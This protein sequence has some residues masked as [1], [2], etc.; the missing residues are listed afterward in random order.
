MGP[1]LE[2][3]FVFCSLFSPFGPSSGTHFSRSLFFTFWPSPGNR[4]VF[5]CL[6]HL[7]VPAIENTCAF[8]SRFHLLGT[9]LENDA[10]S[11]VF[12]TCWAQLRETDLLRVVLFTCVFRGVFSPSGSSSGKQIFFRSL[13]HL[14]GPALE[15]RFVFC[16][17]AQNSQ[18]VW[19]TLN[20]I[21]C[22]PYAGRP[23]LQPGESAF[24][25]P[26]AI[27]ACLANHGVA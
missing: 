3:R 19:I 22:G 10:F 26:D 16:S 4:F 23:P 11:A 25:K 5:R 1:A 8:C 2:N 12:F 27:W 21:L 20:S 9:A 6:L 18:S 15:N 7:L 17:P 24:L 13:S 14:S